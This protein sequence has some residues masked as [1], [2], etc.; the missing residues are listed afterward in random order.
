MVVTVVRSPELPMRSLRLTVPSVVGFQ[1][2]V[3]GLPAVTE[4]PLDGLLNGL[5]VLC[6]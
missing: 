3:N 1:D 5:A 4:Y 6:A 2:R